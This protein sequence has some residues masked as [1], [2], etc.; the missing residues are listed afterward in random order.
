[1]KPVIFGIAGEELNAEEHALF[2][3]CDPA[4]YILFRRNVRDRA[5]LRALTDALRELS[6]REQLPILIDQEGGRVA[7]MQPPVWPEFPRWERFDQLYERAP[8]SAIEAARANAQ[9][10]AI[11]LAECGV[12]VNCLPLLDVRQKDAHDVIG[13]RALGSE[14]TR[15]AAL[16]QAILDGMAEA[17]VAGVMKHIPGHGRTLVDTHKSLPRVSATH[18]ELA[19]DIAPFKALSDTAMAMTAHIV[20]EAWDPD[21]CATLSPI[22]IEQ[23]IRGEI[24]FDGLL[25]TDDLDMKALENGPVQSAVDAIAAGCDIALNCWARIDEMKQT[26]ERLDDISDISR[27]RMERAMATTGV[28]DDSVAL[29]SLIEKRD[30]LLALA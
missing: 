20:F 26:V 22:I 2:R 18:E 4:G 9:A 25:F 5:Q 14:P 16:G 6:G 12:S 19:S 1:M 28:F 29:D 10:I 21:R 24:G 27:Q 8:I 3:D 17:G 30:T 15:V 23:V 7:R 11:T 13:D